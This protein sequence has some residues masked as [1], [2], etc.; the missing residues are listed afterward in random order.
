MNFTSKTHVCLFSLV[1]NRHFQSRFH[2]LYKRQAQSTLALRKWSPHKQGCGS[3][4][5]WRSAFGMHLRFLP[6][7]SKSFTDS[8]VSICLLWCHEHDPYLWWVTG[9]IVTVKTGCRKIYVV[10]IIPRYHVKTFCPFTLEE[11]EALV[12]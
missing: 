9:R 8:D 6:L 10:V 11:L 2:V 7:L 5:E 4:Q 12:A 1:P 3:V